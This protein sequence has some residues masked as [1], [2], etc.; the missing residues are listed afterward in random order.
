[1]IKEECIVLANLSVNV[2]E[3]GEGYPI[4]FLHNGGG[5]WQS[6]QYQMEY[7]SSNYKVYGIDWPGCGESEYPGQPLT[8]EIINNVLT[9]FVEKKG[10]ESMHLIGN[11]IGAS[12]ALDFTI[13][14]PK[15]IN[16]LILFNICPGDLMLPRIVNKS[17]VAKLD[18]FSK[19]KKRTMIAL[20]IISPGFIV[21][22][23][24]PKILFGNSIK[25]NDPLFK[26]YRLKQKQKNQQ[27][28]RVDLFFSAH[29]FNLEPIIKGHIIPNHL[30]LWGEE[31]SVAKLDTYGYENYKTLKS[32][33]FHII[34]N[35]GHL[36]SYEKPDEVN[37]LIEA[38]L[39]SKS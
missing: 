11:C 31:N 3:A 24:F 22:R 33:G 10:I 17:W 6:W 29:S 8:L 2:V 21:R 37:A 14:N 4:L 20:K 19:V 32:D 15:I 27:Q 5:F 39:I 7:F 16:K 12:L 36:C 35:A 1:M 9:A 23:V 26:K 34:P 18:P 25:S 13:R 28:S 38:Y 30:L